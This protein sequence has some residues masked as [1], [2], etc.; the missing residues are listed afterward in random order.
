MNF[1]RIAT[2][3]AI[4]SVVRLLKDM[5]S[6]EEEWAC[7]HDR[8]KYVVAEYLSIISLVAFALA[9]GCPAPA[10]ANHEPD[11]FGLEDQASELSMNFSNR[12]Q[13]WSSR[14][15]RAFSDTTAGSKVA[16]CLSEVSLYL[17]HMGPSS[18]A[19]SRSGGADSDMSLDAEPGR[20][21]PLKILTAQFNAR[22]AQQ[23]YQDQEFQTLPQNPQNLRE[24]P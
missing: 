8:I 24:M 2:T 17:K 10:Q 19:S 21:D 5:P 22:V 1:G 13:S 9:V 3:L 12:S 14:S 6:D 11:P 20:V 4:P 7:L 15:S 18:K 23:G 16:D